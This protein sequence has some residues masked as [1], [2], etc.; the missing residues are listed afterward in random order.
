MHL[1]P[2]FLAVVAASSGALAAPASHTIQERQIQIDVGAI[3]QLVS[4]VENARNSIGGTAAGISDR[5]AG[6]LAGLNGAGQNGLQLVLR[7]FEEDVTKAQDDLGT[8]ASTLQSIISSFQGTE[9][10][11]WPVF[12]DA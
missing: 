11:T 8:I 12:V 5:V 9:E 4:D 2:L 10:E 3:S 7:R 1:S 6:T